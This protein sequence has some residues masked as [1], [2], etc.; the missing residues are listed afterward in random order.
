VPDL[1]WS[2]ADNGEELPSSVCGVI[3][4][5]TEDLGAIPIQ[6]CTSLI[7]E[8]FDQDDDIDFFLVP[9]QRDEKCNFVGRL[10]VRYFRWRTMDGTSDEPHL[11]SGT[12]TEEF[13]KALTKES[14][15]DS[16]SKEYTDTPPAS[17]TRL[18]M[19]RSFSSLV[20]RL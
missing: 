7:H 14:T 3:V 10:R 16:D 12:S 5:Q 17:L 8:N 19:V 11:S 18:I 15:E 20:R 6:G 1:S 9:I 13:A 2:T 4:Y